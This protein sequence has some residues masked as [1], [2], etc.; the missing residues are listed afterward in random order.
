MAAAMPFMVAVPAFRVALPLFMAVVLRCG[1]E[2]KGMGVPGG[3]AGWRVPEGGS[4]PA[5]EEAEAHVPAEEGHVP[6]E[7][8]GH[9]PA[10]PGACLATVGPAPVGMRRVISAGTSPL[11]CPY[12]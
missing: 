7:E 11:L 10:D 8:E 6:P 1:T 12:A 9:V 4:E 3:R 2:S 5:Q